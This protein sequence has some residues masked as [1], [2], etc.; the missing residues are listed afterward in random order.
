MRFADHRV[1]E[2]SKEAYIRNSSWV[3]DGWQSTSA[4]G[5]F[6]RDYLLLRHSGNLREYISGELRYDTAFG[7]Q[8]RILSSLF[9][10]VTDFAILRFQEDSGVRTADEN[11]LPTGS[12]CIGHLV[13]QEKWWLGCWSVRRQRTVKWSGTKYKIVAGPARR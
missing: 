5:P 6:E 7:V 13:S 11:F 12:M 4:R 8:S 1:R 9:S 2:P 10:M 3:K